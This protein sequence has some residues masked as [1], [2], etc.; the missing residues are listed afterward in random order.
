MFSPPWFQ[1]FGGERPH[2]PHGS[3]AFDIIPTHI[4]TLA[5][6]SDESS[7]DWIGIIGLD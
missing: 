6:M 3:N 2:C 7:M 4:Y 5:L 1:H